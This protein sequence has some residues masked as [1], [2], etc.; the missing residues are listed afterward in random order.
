MAM[1]FLTSVSIITDY[2]TGSFQ[3][4]QKIIKNKV[5]STELQ[6]CVHLPV[7]TWQSVNSVSMSQYHPDKET[8]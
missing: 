5:I 1:F 3:Q 8:W 7:L 2:N 4:S 6:H